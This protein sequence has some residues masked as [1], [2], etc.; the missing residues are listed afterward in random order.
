MIRTRPLRASTRAP[1]GI[2]WFAVKMKGLPPGGVTITVP[3]TEPA[4]TLLPATGVGALGPAPVIGPLGP[5]GPLGPAGPVGPP[6]PPPP[7]P[8]PPPPPLVVAVTQL[9]SS[10][11]PPAVGAV[12]VAVAVMTG[13]ATGGRVKLNGAWPAPSVVT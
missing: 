3:E 13:P 6:P 8:P 2:V 11:V 9:E 1:K 7:V 5:L 4:T 10:D 12:R